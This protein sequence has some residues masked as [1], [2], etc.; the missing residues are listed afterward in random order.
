[1]SHT[2]YQIIGKTYDTAQRLNGIRLFTIIYANLASHVS[3][4]FKAYPNPRVCSLQVL[5]LRLLTSY[6]SRTTIN[7]TVRRKI[8]RAS[9]N[10]RVSFQKDSR[11]NLI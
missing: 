11:T 8:I 1:M 2:A 10:P 3:S 6:L 9:Q 4:K 5:P 7:Q